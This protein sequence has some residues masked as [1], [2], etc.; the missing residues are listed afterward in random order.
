MRAGRGLLIGW[1]LAALVLFA[2]D[3]RLAVFLAGP[4]QVR[5][6]AL[7]SRR[8]SASSAPPPSSTSPAGH[9]RYQIADDLHQPLAAVVAAAEH[10]AS[11]APFQQSP[12]S[13]VRGGHR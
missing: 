2:L 8:W 3:G 11:A 6:W 13:P 12:Q 5:S 1:L 4:S 9:N 7:G 10:D